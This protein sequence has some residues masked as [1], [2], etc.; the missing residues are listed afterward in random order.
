MTTIANEYVSDLI[1]GRVSLALSISLGFV[2]NRRSSGARQRVEP[3]PFGEEALT[4]REFIVI[5]ENPKSVRR[6]LPSGPI[7]MFD[8]APYSVGRE[9]GSRTRDLHFLGPHE[10]PRRNARN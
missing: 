6:G 9:V 7:R 1:V 8:C 4:E 3:L 10:P 2:D 5:D